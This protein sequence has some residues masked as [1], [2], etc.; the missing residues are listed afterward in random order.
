MITIQLCG[1]IILGIIIYFSSNQN[2]LR[3]KT[4]I[5][6]LITLNNTVVTLLLDIISI[7]AIINS[8]KIHYFI[9]EKIRAM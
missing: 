6:Y 9:V 3:L 7:L 1:M 5:I 4:N 8:D 2:R